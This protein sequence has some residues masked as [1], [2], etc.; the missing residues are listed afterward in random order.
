M[1]VRLR[2][3][4]LDVFKLTDDFYFFFRH[5]DFLS[6][7]YSKFGEEHFIYLSVLGF[8]VSVEWWD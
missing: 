6:L 7:G 8:Q 3:K 5:I 4:A 1:K 2:C